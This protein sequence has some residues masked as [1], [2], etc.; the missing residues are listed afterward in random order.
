MGLVEPLLYESDVTIAA[1]QLRRSGAP[2]LLIHPNDATP[3]QIIA[4][5]EVRI[6][7]ERGSFFAVAEVSDAV[8]PGVVACARGRWPSDSK[9][10]ATINATV[11]DRDSDMGR[12]AFYHDNRVRVDRVER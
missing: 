9:Q 3:R 10:G 8:R 6:A 7:N 12:G 2:A 11:D 4:G 5:D 1:R